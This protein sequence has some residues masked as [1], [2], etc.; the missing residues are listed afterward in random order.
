[1]WKEKGKGKG[2]RKWRKR[3]R[4]LEEGQILAG[5]VAEKGD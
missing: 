1:L 2:E 4:S 5:D 3:R